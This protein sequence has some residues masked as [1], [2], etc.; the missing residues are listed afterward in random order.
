MD[1]IQLSSLDHYFADFITR[2]EGTSR[3]GLWI[4]A[5]LVSAVSCR[6]S[7][8]L[9]LSRATGYGIVPFQPES[10]PLQTPALERWR[11]LLAGC[12]TVGTP[13]DYTPLVLDAAGRLYLHRSWDYERR[14]AEGILARSALLSIDAAGFA[15]ALDRYFP[16]AGNEGDLQREAALAALTRRF[17]VISGGPGTG[18]TSTVARILALLIELADGD[19]PVILLA[20]PTGKAAMR[21]KQSLG[22]SAEQ[23]PLSES[24]RFAMP[25]EVS[26]VHRLLG[27]IPGQSGFR[28]DRNNQLLCDVLVVDEASMIDLPLMARLLE[29]VRTD[30]RIILLGDRDQL[31]S[32]EAGAVMSDICA[33]GGP[34]TV[35]GDR[36][37]IIQLTKS[38]RFND[39]SGIGVL[40]RLINAGDGIGALALLTSGLHVDVCWR[41]LPPDGAFSES[42]KLAAGKGFAAYAR[43]TS[44]AAAL[45]EL[46]RF[47]ILAPHR[48]GRQGVV[49]LNRLV[50]S[51]LLPLRLDSSAGFPLLPVMVTGNNYDLGLYNGDTGVVMGTRAEE[52]Q[53][54]FFPAPDAELRRFSSLRLP[55]HETAFVLTVHKTQGS[56]FDRVLLILP[57]QLSDVL[58]RELLYTAVTRAR[59]RLEIWGKEEVFCRA[60]ERCIERRSGLADRLWKGVQ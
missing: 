21:L 38:Y 28:H 55:P 45:E 53:A 44:P 14:V 32:V 56:E 22:Q 5:A 12:A 37:A 30:T 60:V 3:D 8:C 36:P 18:K 51:V 43:A 24:V 16:L 54:V 2:I 41:P 1:V 50:E 34:D 19:P 40:S 7:V 52:G 9:D 47:R 29:A 35:T 42:F 20:A 23:L 13:G 15:A 4:A 59:T 49:T 57:D 46:E 27:V 33:G 17:T 58:S 10:G 26:T 25:L 48:E 11:E 6:G 39:Q 31:A